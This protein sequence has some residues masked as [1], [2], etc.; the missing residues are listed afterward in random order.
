MHFCSILPFFGY[1]NRFWD[2]LGTH[3]VLW[4]HLLEGTNGLFW[5]YLQRVWRV[6]VACFGAT[7][8][9]FWW[10]TG[11][12]EKLTFFDPTWTALRA[13][14]WG[15]N[16]CSVVMYP[17]VFK[18]AYWKSIFRNWVVSSSYTKSSSSQLSSSIHPRILPW[19]HILVLPQPLVVHR[20]H[21]FQNVSSV[22]KIAFTWIFIF[23]LVIMHLLVMRYRRNCRNER[24]K[25]FKVF[26]SKSNLS[27]L[28]TWC[29]A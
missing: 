28:V 22:L 13:P 7:R 15:K 23:V 18:M 10:C 26:H 1:Q 16:S 6:P 5:K 12:S 27:G 29:A 9:M 11:G 17:C 8:S 14:P 3:K 2:V 24:M 19:F 20:P 21:W 4:G 25:V